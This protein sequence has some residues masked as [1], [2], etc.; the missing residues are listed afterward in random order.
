MLVRG[1]SGL[2]LLLLTAAVLSGCNGQP[3]QAEPTGTTASSGG[4]SSAVLDK[5]DPCALLTVDQLQQYS[6]ATQG[7]PLNTSDETGCIYLGSPDSASR[8]INL[9]KSKDSVDSYVQ[10][11][12]TFVKLT[13]NT[14]NGRNGVQTQISTSN[15]E[16]SQ[17]IAV[18]SGTVRVAVTNDKSGDPCGDALKIAQ[19]VEPKLPK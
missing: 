17:V 10:R 18:G 5:L 7:Q 3:G 16:C 19:V 13:K 12:D 4:S 8:G 6:V 9:S 1:V 14:V 15:T 2:G 11:S